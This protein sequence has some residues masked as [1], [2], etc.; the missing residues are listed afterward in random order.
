VTI[1]DIATKFK[2]ADIPP[3]TTLAQVQRADE[4]INR[5]A[6]Q[7]NELLP[8]LLDAGCIVSF[9][10]D[11]EGTQ[12]SVFMP[13]QSFIKGTAPA[14]MAPAYAP[15]YALVDAYRAGAWLADLPAAL[16]IATE[17]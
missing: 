2:A 13:D 12:A 5:V 4:E 11:E 3:Q 16:A 6:G 10:A 9:S 7:P 17:A 15:M 1:T 14:G 8:R